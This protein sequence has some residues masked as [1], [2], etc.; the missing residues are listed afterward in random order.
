[1]QRGGSL[2]Y[3]GERRRGGGVGPPHCAAVASPAK[4]KWEPWGRQAVSHQPQI[5]APRFYIHTYYSIN[6]RSRTQAPKPRARRRHRYRRTL[7]AKGTSSPKDRSANRR[8]AARAL[9]G[10]P[11]ALFRLGI[12][13]FGCE[14]ACPRD[15]ARRGD[16][17]RRLYASRP[18]KTLRPKISQQTNTTLGEFSGLDTRRSLPAAVTAR[19]RQRRRSTRARDGSASPEYSAGYEEK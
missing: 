18:G 17:K 13:A 8:G 2:A 10:Q 15:V 4:V 9:R 3:G 19:R 7:G 14:L 11:G 12:S 6:A 16:S 1:M 5:R